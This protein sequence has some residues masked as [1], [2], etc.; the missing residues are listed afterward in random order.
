LSAPNSVWSIGPR[1]LLGLFDAGRRQAEV[2]RAHAVFDEAGQRYRNTTLAA[3][4]QVED[5]LALLHLLG[6]EAVHEDA[7]VA[8]AQRTL[9]LALDRYRNGAVNYLEAQT[10]ALQAQHTALALH[11]RRLRASVALVRALGGGWDAASAQSIA[12]AAN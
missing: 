1:A 11:G 9:N 3:F 5:N 12:A 10:A 4:Q 7:A 8:S 2:G 6:D